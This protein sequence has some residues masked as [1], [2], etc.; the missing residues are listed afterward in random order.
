MDSSY[1]RTFQ[2]TEFLF[3]GPLNWYVRYRWIISCKFSLFSFV[4]RCFF[5]S[6]LLPLDDQTIGSLITIQFLSCFATYFFS[7][8]HQYSSEISSIIPGL[9]VASKTFRNIWSKGSFFVSKFE[10][11]LLEV[12]LSRIRPKDV[13]ASNLTN[14]DIRK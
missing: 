14:W 3:L 9:W 12:V 11:S 10:Y 8:S 7:S 4:N 13:I 2:N 6:F 5:L 1:I